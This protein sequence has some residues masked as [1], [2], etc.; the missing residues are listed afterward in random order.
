MM[1]V[2]EIWMRG[3]GL[4]SLILGFGVCVRLGLRYQRCGMMVDG[5]C[6]IEDGEDGEEVRY[7]DRAAF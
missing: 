4:V 6:F 1:I 3:L 7:I 5:F 2:D